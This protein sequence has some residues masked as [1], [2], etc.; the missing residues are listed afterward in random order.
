MYTG[1]ELVV[2]DL[3]NGEAI[4]YGNT[5]QDATSRVNLEDIPLFKYEELA[6]ATDNFSE[7][8]KLGKG[9][10]G[11][12]YKVLKCVSC[13]FVQLI[14]SVSCLLNITDESSAKL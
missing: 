4:E 11:P 9:G 12:V 2:H 3:G 5:T 8:N 10:F 1:F 7:A 6:N 13:L 14:L